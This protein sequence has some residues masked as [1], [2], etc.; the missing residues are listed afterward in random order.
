MSMEHKAY[1]FDYEEF[2]NELLPI[3]DLALSLNDCSQIASFVDN[4]R[5]ALTDPN[6]G[7]PLG[8][9]W[10]DLIETYDVH[11]FGDFALTKYYQPS[12]DE[13]LADTWKMVDDELA[14]AFGA[15]QVS[16]LGH[17]V[18]PKQE[19]FDPGKMGAY[20][21]SPDAVAA[22]LAKIR[23]LDREIMTVGIDSW[24]QVLGRAV[25]QGKGLYVTF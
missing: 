1:Q 10:R 3:L 4:Y 2:S 17:T 7:E 21:Q 24:R 23:V 19:L 8:E 14:A 11:Q 13:G 12:N 22:G 15:G 6:E 25:E 20:F 16:V 9:K 18:G 5:E